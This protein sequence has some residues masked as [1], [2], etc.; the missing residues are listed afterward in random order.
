MLLAYFDAK[1]RNVLARISIIKYKSYSSYVHAMSCSKLCNWSRWHHNQP[2]KLI[3][4]IHNAYLC[5]G[6]W[7][8]RLKRGQQ[9]GGWVFI[10]DNNLI[11]N[12]VHA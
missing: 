9:Y 10:T 8:L 12:I 4:K 7:G 2:R 6:L 3:I 5:Q 11:T 1:Y